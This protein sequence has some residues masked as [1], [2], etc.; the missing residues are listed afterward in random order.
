MTIQNN[1]CPTKKKIYVGFDVGER[2]G[3]Q[4]ILQSRPIVM[5][6]S[7]WG[8]RR[9]THSQHGPKT[10]NQ[11]LIRVSW[12]WIPMSIVFIRGPLRTLGS[13]KPTQRP[14]GL[15]LPFQSSP[16]PY[17]F[18]TGP[19][20]AFQAH[21]SNDQQNITSLTGRVTGQVTVILT[22]DICGAYIKAVQTPPATKNIFILLYLPI[23]AAGKYF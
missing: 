2:A 17:F 13:C 14:F 11:P 12:T 6:Y 15:A 5:N 8:Q 3:F 4:M 21:E 19:V 9:M 10:I 16:D 7:P 23:N 22:V 1:Y 18:W 20:L